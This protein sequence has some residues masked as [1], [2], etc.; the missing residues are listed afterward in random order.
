ML[1]VQYDCN[2]LQVFVIWFTVVVV[3][4]VLSALIAFLCCGNRLNLTRDNEK[5]AGR[6]LS[7]QE[8]DCGVCLIAVSRIVRRVRAL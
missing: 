2:W 5:S 3:V 1:L 4:V 8:V 6:R 7:V